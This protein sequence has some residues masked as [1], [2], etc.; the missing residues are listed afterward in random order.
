MRALCT[1]PLRSTLKASRAMPAHRAIALPA[2]SACCARAGPS[3]ATSS[4]ALHSG[5][6]SCPGHWRCRVFSLA[7]SAVLG[8]LARLACFCFGFFSC[9][10]STVWAAVNRLL[11]VPSESGLISSF[12]SSGFSAL[13]FRL[14][15]RLL[16]AGRDFVR[17]DFGR[18]GSR[19]EFDHD[20]RRICQQISRCYS[21]AP[22]K[23]QAP[24]VWK[25]QR[26]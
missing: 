12:F 10:F 17:R 23:R 22:A 26:A 13:G 1:P 7:V 3:A 4:S 5:C 19:R 16:R 25:R 14:G 24:A 18:Y 11:G 21:N 9:G 8:A 2:D 15:F 20:H 6:V